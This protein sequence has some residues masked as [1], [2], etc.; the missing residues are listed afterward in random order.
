MPFEINGSHMIKPLKLFDLHCDT[1]TCLYQHGTSLA[2]NPHHVSLASGNAFA[3]YTQVMAIYPNRA[4][5]DELAF[6]HF[7]KVADYLMWQFEALEDRVTYVRTAGQYQN[8]PTPA[9]AFLAV[10]DARLLCGKRDR[11]RILHARGVRFL[12]LV[13]GGESCIGGAHNTAV[14]LTEFGKQTV[15]DCFDMG[16]VPD[17]SHASEQTA[18]EILALAQAKGKPAIASHSASYTVNPHSRNLR[19]RHFES[20]KSCGGLV[21]LCLYT[22]HLCDRP[23]AH[24]ADIIRHVEHYLALG[25]QNTVALGSDFDGAELPEEIRG[26]SDLTKLAEELARLNYSET[27][28]HKLFYE[29]AAEFVSKNLTI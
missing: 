11:L 14:G 26:P 4:L 28:I 21:G 16:I 15:N 9:T 13:W 20:V 19:D 29:N 17:I 7:H 23:T 24:I 25:G 8:A 22:R 10:E 27:L 2:K 6:R 1:A 5:D 12:T 3:H 18:D